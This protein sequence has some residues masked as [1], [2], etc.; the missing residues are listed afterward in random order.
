MNWPRLLRLYTLVAAVSAVSLIVFAEQFSGGRFAILAVAVGV[1]AFVSVIAGALL[2][3]GAYLAET[4]PEASSP[5][6]D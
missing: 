5:S 3:G 1:V 4:G 2:A 6:G